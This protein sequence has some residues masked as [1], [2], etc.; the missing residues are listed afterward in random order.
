[1]FTQDEIL[2]R[3]Q[4]GTPLEE[5]ADEMAKAL[6]LA[7]QEYEKTKTNPRVEA[8]REVVAAIGNY[9]IVDGKEGVAKELSDMY[10][11]D[12]KLLEFCDSMDMVISLFEMVT[13]TGTAN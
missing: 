10:N 4:K 1:M 6:N 9:L 8:M 13:G 5:I 12:N 3:L 11:D 7:R 2:K